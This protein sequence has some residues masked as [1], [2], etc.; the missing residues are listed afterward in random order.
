M[1]IPNLTPASHLLQQG[2]GMG[3]HLLNP[4][5]FNQG[6]SRLSR[7]PSVGSNRLSQ[8]QH[9]FPGQQQQQPMSPRGVS[10]TG[11]RLGHVTSL[12][13]QSHARRLGIGSSLLRQL[14]YHLRECHMADSVGLHV[15]VSNLQ[16]VRLYVAEGYD[17]A[18]IMPFYY[19]DGE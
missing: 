12:G 5:G 4:A 6:F 10:V 14:H 8:Q 15:R 7:Q 1:N 2:A 9:G 17:V 11:E 19:G 16:A 18:D 13:V 3:N